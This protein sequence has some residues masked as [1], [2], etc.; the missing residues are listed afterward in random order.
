MEAQFWQE[1]WQKNEIGFHEPDVNPLLVEHI[2][3]LAL[4]PGDRIFLP[5]C[6]KT[7]DIAWLL[8]QGYR[9]VGVEL[10]ELAIE[11]LFAEMEVEP[12]ISS[13]GKM[14]H[15]Q[16]PGIDIYVGDLFDLTADILGTV[17]AVYDRAAFVALPPQMREK[18][19]AKITE[20]TCSAD[21]LLI[22]FE[23]DQSLMNGP[24]FSST[25][26]DIENSYQ[27]AYQLTLLSEGEMPGGLKGHSAD[28]FVW[29]LRQE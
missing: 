8:S 14:L 26:S 20:V 9:I 5:L 4:E 1:K 19:A 15:Y 21:Q 2:S 7:L 18:Y 3:A 29:L 16:A 27:A 12:D 10:V 23:Y 13:A 17:D 6:G 28:E 22:T 24:P 11:Q 25:H